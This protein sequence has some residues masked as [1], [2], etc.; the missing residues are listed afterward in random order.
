[1]LHRHKPNVTDKKRTQANTYFSVH[2][3]TGEQRTLLRIW[4]TQNRVTPPQRY[5][6]CDKRRTRT[7]V[8]GKQNIS[9]HERDGGDRLITRR[10]ALT[11]TAVFFDPAQRY[12]PTFRPRPSG[13]LRCRRRPSLSSPSVVTTTPVEPASYGRR[14]WCGGGGG[15]V[16][17]KSA[18]SSTVSCSTNTIYGGAR[19]SASHHC[20][21]LVID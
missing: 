12:G 13:T 9:V 1:M 10:W 18:P 21:E 14:P 6:T 16:N 17:W 5:Q 3:R 2:L 20:L 7:G 19:V 15:G 4:K 11:M 8:S